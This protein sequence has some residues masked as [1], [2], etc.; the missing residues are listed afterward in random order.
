MEYK[1]ST[2]QIR[3]FRDAGYLRLGVKL[4]DSFIDKMTSII[5]AHFEN[6]VPPFRVNDKGEIKRLDQLLSRDPIFLEVLRLPEILQPLQSLLRSNIEILKYRHNHA[7]LNFF[8]DIPFRLHRDIQQWS[9][10][11]ISV[12]IFLE[13]SLYENGCT[14]I[15]PTSQ[16]LPF[17]GN[18]S[19]DGGGNWAD[20]H[21]IYKFV[22][23]QALP[24]PMPK[25]GI[26]I[27]DSLAF[28]SVG[29]NTTNSSRIS[30]VFAFHSVD[31]LHDCPSDNSRILLSGTRF[32][33]GTDKLKFSG[34]LVKGEQFENN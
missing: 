13:D 5:K 29:L 26:L 9:R 25:G 10:P 34:S 12:F 23:E 7:T 30:T 28:H 6:K 31:D 3:F 20:E 4:Q 24:I 19:D 14:H 16:F 18:Q 1:L 11:V 27:L 17:A 32:Y 15:V 21:E 22:I 2:D 8:N 33:K